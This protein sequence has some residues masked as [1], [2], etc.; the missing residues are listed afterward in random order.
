M[1]NDHV[2]IVNAFVQSRKTLLT[3][4]MVGNKSNAT[5]KLAGATEADLGEKALWNSAS[6]EHHQSGSLTGRDC[7]E[8]LRGRLLGEPQ[9]FRQRLFVAVTELTV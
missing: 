3:S 7:H 1:R 9:R 2:G 4:T 8:D 5:V 6:R